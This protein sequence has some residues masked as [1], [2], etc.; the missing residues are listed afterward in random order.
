MNWPGYYAALVK[1]G[2]NDKLTCIAMLGNTAKESASSFWPCREAYYIYDRDPRIAEPLYQANP[3]PAINWFNNTKEHAAYAGGWN[4]H[5]R[6]YIQTTHD[7]NYRRVQDVTGIPCLSNPDLLLEP[8]N[9]A[10]AMCVFAI[11]HNMK[12]LAQTKD[13]AA[14]RKAVFGGNDPDGIARIQQVYNALG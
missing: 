3:Q 8:A 1:Y 13:W 9:A 14:C 7:Y 12:A 11:D 10:E 4:Y 5:G 6:G 2:L